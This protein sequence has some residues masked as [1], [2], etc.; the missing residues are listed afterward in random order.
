MTD[1]NIS[2]RALKTTQGSGVPVFSF[3]LKGRDILNVADISRISRETT[4]D[5]RGFQRKEIRRHVNSIADYLDRDEVIFPN[6]IIL[7]FSSEAEFKQSRGPVPDGVEDTAAVGTLTLPLRPEGRRV[8]WIVDGQ[9]R[10]LALQKTL[11]GDLPVP[12]V[13]FLAKNLE[14]QREQFILVNKA[15]PLPRRLITELLPEI[16]TE[17]P[18]DLKPVKIPSELCN[19]LNLDPAS[20][21][22]G[23]IKRASSDDKL[24]N[25]VIQDTALINVMKASINN[26]GALALFKQ[27]GNVP[28]DI[29]AMYGIM[30]IYWTAVKEVFPE[31]WG[32]RPQESRLMHSAGIQALGILMDR[33]I[34]RLHQSDDLPG[35]VKLALERIA[36]QCRWT[37]GEWE[38]LGMTW[39][40]IQNVPRHIKALAEHL[41][42]ID[43]AA[44][45][46]KPQLTS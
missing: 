33:I 35:S 39:N 20:P 3:F 25:A 46:T 32:K 7:A 36:P 14:T 9:Q 4:G 11:N 6:A 34:P 29:N 30:C 38:G 8:A 22:F 1:D 15:K 19:L 41:V 10:S 12:I 27:T 16:G 26:Y 37:E 24:T 28:G 31:A 13:G 5:L 17:L 21:F 2:V 23:L 42:Q 45:Q 43:F 44:S 40:E 18:Y